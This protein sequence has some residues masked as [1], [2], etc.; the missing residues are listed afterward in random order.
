MILDALE[1]LLD[2][3]PLKDLSVELIAEKAG[4]T[5]TRFYHYFNSK[6]EAYAALLQRV[7]DEV[8]AVYA[9]PGS[10]MHRS[11]QARPREALAATVRGVSEVWLS[12][13]AVMREGADLWNTVPEAR[14]LWHLMVGELVRRMTRAI[15][16][17][18]A[19][20][21]APAGPDAGKLA[22]ALIWQG[23]RLLFLLLADAPGAL[24]A[25]DLVEVT[26]TAWMRAIYGAD[27][28]D[29]R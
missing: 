18:R 3:T 17:E 13:G 2:R 24:T 19:R 9:L 29:P 6:Y 23:E 4:I 27:D 10:W 8:L 26:L 7:T 16:R 14:D 5:R 20:G 22:Y 15:E 25:D 12:H 28:P 21:M 11:Q 1:Q